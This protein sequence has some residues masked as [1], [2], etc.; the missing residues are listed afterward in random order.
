MSKPLSFKRCINKMYFEDF[1]HE[2]KI[3]Y[4]R[5]YLNDWSD[6][7]SFVGLDD[8]DLV[9]NELIFVNTTLGDSS[10]KSTSNLIN[11]FD[12]GT[13]VTDI[14]L[15]AFI[16][17]LFAKKSSNSILSFI[18]CCYYLLSKFNFSIALSTIAG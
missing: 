15:P 18:F 8:I 13:S 16:S 6:L 4:K 5:K 12:L 3:E 11:F 9:N 10:S 17:I 7:R 1:Y 2:N 14:T